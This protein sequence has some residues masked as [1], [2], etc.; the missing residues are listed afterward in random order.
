M[1]DA[2]FND[3]PVQYESIV[4]ATAALSFNMNSDLYTG[5]RE[6]TGNLKKRRTNTGTGNRRRT[7]N[8]M[9]H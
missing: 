5:S 1:E 9:D 6:N 8:I 7:G 3:I 2:V 4:K